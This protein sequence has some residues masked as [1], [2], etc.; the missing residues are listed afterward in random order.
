MIH[1]S[2]LC[3]SRVIPIVSTSHSNAFLPANKPFTDLFTNAKRENRICGSP[4]SHSRFA[5]LAFARRR[6]RQFL[7]YTTVSLPKIYSPLV[8]PCKGTKFQPTLQVSIP[9]SYD[10]AR[11]RTKLDNANARKTAIYLAIQKKMSNF[12]HKKQTT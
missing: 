1:G 8:S 9:I 5:R 7:D 12:T 6:Q 3:F 4:V 2:S 10:I 11:P